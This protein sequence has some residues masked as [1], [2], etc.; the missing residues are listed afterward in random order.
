MACYLLLLLYRMV[1]GFTSAGLLPS[2]YES[3]CQGAKLG[4]LNEHYI[5]DGK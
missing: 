2:Q 4:Y 1:H 3:L 5:A